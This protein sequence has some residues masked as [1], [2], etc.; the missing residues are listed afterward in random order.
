[1][2][3]TIEKVTNGA[4]V[5]EMNKV[6]VFTS[7]YELFCYITKEVWPDE[8]DQSDALSDERPDLSPWARGLESMAC[9]LPTASSKL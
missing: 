6:C 2:R 8:V 3:I 7:K 4:I 5:T 1:M 9:D